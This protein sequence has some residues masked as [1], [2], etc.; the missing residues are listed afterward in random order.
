MRT[1]FY[2]D[3][4]NLYYGCVRNT[5]Y[6]WLNL[7]EFCLKSLP[8]P[9]N[10]LRRIRYFAAIVKA[11]NSDP[12]QPV[13]QQ[14]L[15]R[16]FKTIPTISIHLGQ[17]LATKVKMKL[18]TPLADGTTS[19]LVHK[20]EEKGSDVNLGLFRIE[21][22][23]SLKKVDRL[24]TLEV[25]SKQP[26][27]GKPCPPAYC[28]KRSVSVATSTAEPVLWRGACASP[29]NNPGNAIAAPDAVR[30][31][32]MPRGTKTASCKPCRSASSRPLSWSRWR[33]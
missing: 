1:N 10:E 5:R 20:S 16:A 18:V 32:S 31:R 8:P 30:R 15:L 33:G 19:V 22:L 7:H 12:Q 6:K 23:G 25:T 17:F 13:R 24:C 9:R 27:R 11:R 26:S 14:T 3:A 4:F 29:S 28:I 2:V 21:R